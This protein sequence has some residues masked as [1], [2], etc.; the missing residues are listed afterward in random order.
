MKNH[1]AEDSYKHEE[2]RAVDSYKHEESKSCRF[3]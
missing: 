3:I 2:S 1:R